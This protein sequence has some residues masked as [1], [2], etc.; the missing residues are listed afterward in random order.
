MKKIF[1]IIVALILSS[2]VYASFT[3]S[4]EWR[5]DSCQ[6]TEKPVLYA[7]NEF[8]SDDSP[9]SLDEILSSPV[10]ISY[11]SGQ[12]DQ[13][14]CCSSPYDNLG[15]KTIPFGDSCGENSQEIMYTTSNTNAR[16]AVQNTPGFDL[17]HYSHKIC[18]DKPEEF[19]TIDMFINKTDSHFES[20][21]YSCVYRTSS[22]INGLVSSCDATFDGGKK[23][24]YSVFT[25]MW[26][27][28][29]SLDC[30]SDCTSKLD[31]R[32]YSSCG[33][34]INSCRGIHPSCDGSIYGGWVVSNSSIEQEVQ[35]S[36]PWNNFRGGFGAFE[37][38]E[39]SSEESSCSNL[40][41]RDYQVMVDNQ[42]TN[43]KILICS[44]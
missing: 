5:A 25:R 18:L 7:H 28:E 40:I 21:G 12:F 19:A 44:E 43:L 32:V 30:N 17:N 39:I 9:S 27:T 38:L 13:V 36:G 15:F 34:Q 1:F 16:L 10:S 20:V 4:C 33:S 8:G 3:L 41:S 37:D 31:G 14:L 42:I 2:G 6:G 26:Q 23:Y 29:S 24:E 11:S 22:L 35:C